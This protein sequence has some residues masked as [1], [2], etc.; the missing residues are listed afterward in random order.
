M[1]DLD[2]QIHDETLAALKK[3]RDAY[4]RYIEIVGAQQKAVA[5][6]N[7]S[8]MR[9]LADQLDGII[10]EIEEIG[11]QL[12][13]VYQSISSG[14]VDGLHVQ[15]VRDQMTAVT[16]DAALAQ[17]NVR[18]LTQLLVKGRDE[19]RQQLES[20]DGTAQSPMVDSP[21]ENKPPNLIDTRR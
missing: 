12:M 9:G 7:L 10:A 20:M 6:G 19:T 13:P 3:Q 16:A 15:A 1:P 11:N 21:L 14:Q 17:A 5:N 18:K 4:A 2:K 8:L